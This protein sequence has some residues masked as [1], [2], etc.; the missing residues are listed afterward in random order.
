MDFKAKLKVVIGA[1]LI[2]GVLLLTYEIFFY[3]T[4]VYESSASV[5]TDFTNISAQI[6]GKIDEIL[7]KEGDPVKKGQLIISLVQDDIALNIDSLK[8]DLAL[9]QA[10]RIR[11]AAEKAAFDAELRSEEETQKEIIRTFSREYKS[12]HERLGLAKENLRRVSVLFQ[13]KLTPESALN[14]EQ[15]KVLVL[16]GAE[17]RY[18]GK[19]AVARREQGQLNASRTQLDVLDAKI[20][21]SDIKQEQIRDLIKKQALALG[22]R[23][24]TSPLDGMVGA[25]HKYKGEYVEDGVDI[26][27]LHDPRSYWIEANIDESQIRHV[28]VGQDVRINLDAYPFRDFFGSVQRIGNVTT[29]SINPGSTNG[30]NARKLGSSTVRVPVRISLKSPPANLTPGM[31][32]DVNIR[33]YENIKLW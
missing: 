14:A 11:L 16:Q 17:S 28:I 4:H 3:V 32:A 33:I 31:R 10:N 24:I 9:E 2:G 5:Q 21:V 19:I 26:L 6:D 23:H 22:Y 20:R 15:S 25:I 7:V 30:S 12:L 13:K 1:G 27:M 29:N 8:T 18:R